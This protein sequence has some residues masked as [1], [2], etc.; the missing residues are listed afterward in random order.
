M[1]AA[2]RDAREAIALHDPIAADNDIS[3]ALDLTPQTVGAAQS[4]ATLLGSFPVRVH[5][6]SAQALL[7][8]GRVADA[9]TLLMEIQS[10]VP[11]R[12]MPHDLPLLAAADS[13]ER[14]R[15]A[16]SLGTPQLR[17]QLLCAVAALRDYRGTAYAQETMA[18]ASALDRALA[19]PTQLRTLLPAQVGIWLA[20]VMQLTGT[21]RSA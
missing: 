19:H 12:L 13:L 1:L 2:V 16:A 15:V 8:Q 21:D 5:L 17:T 10:R 11:G 7:T 4:L 20:T 9:D 18:L 3:Q 6:V 14:A